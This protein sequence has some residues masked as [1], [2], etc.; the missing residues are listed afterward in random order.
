MSKPIKPL[1]MFK[2]DG[3]TGDVQAFVAEIKEL[4]R[5]KDTPQG[6][7][8]TPFRC[9]V[10]LSDNSA[11]LYME[12]WKPEAD[13]PFKL[14]D[15]I[16]INDVHSEYNDYFKSWQIKTCSKSKAQVIDKSAQRKVTETEFL[17]KMDEVSTDPIKPKSFEEVKTQTVMMPTTPEHRPYFP[18]MTIFELR[19]YHLNEK[20]G[21]IRGHIENIIMTKTLIDTLKEF[22]K[23]MTES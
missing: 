10:K 5:K 16:F 11:E 14:N 23:Y 12:I 3:I 22:I 1:A 8:G 6:K 17:A 21:D 4:I 7:A 13:L 20:R 2:Q 15:T 19:D 18:A 9:N